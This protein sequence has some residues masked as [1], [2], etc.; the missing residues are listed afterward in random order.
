MITAKDITPIWIHNLGSVKKLFIKKI[1]VDIFNELPDTEEY[2]S[3]RIKL[4]SILNSLWY[5]APEILNNSWIDIYQF[6]ES[7]IN[8]EA[9]NPQWVKN[10]IVIWEKGNEQFPKDV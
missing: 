5:K 1:I 4:T 3:A 8:N 2:K 9:E 6:L 10:I 7:Y